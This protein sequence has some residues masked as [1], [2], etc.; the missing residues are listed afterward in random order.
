MTQRDEA[1]S[2]SNCASIFSRLYGKYVTVG[3]KLTLGLVLSANIC[4][5]LF[6]YHNWSAHKRI[7]EQVDDVMAIKDE[8]LINLRDKVFEMERNYLSIP[9]Q[10]A[11]DPFSKQLSWIQEAYQVVSTQTIK[12]RENYTTIFSRDERR[13][14][15]LGRL[16]V[17]EWESK[18]IAAHIALDDDQ[19]I[20]GTLIILILNSETPSATVEKITHEID[21]I[22]KIGFDPMELE[23]RIL[24]LGD[25]LVQAG[26]NAEEHRNQI[27]YKIE[28][29]QNRE[30]DLLA[31][32]IL[33]N[34]RFAILSVITVLLTALVL[35]ILTRIIVE[36]P[37]LQLTRVI[38]A[39]RQGGSPEIPYL[40]RT[41]QIGLLSGALSDFNE[42]VIEL[43]RSE[44]R[45]RKAKQAAEAANLAKS[46]FLANMSHEI[47]TP[48]NGVLGMLQLLNATP[49]DGSQLD[50]VETARTSAHSLLTIINDILDF[51][52]IEA[53]RLELETIHF[54]LRE[55]IDETRSVMF[56]HAE[57]KNLE[58]TAV[59][60]PDVPS[61]FKGD[62]G[63]IRQIIINLLSNAIKFT[64]KG[65][66]MLTANLI[67]E[68]A[69]TAPCK[70]ELKI[71]VTAFQRINSITC[72]LHFPSWMRPSQENMVAQDW[73]WPSQNN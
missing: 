36:R 37:L 19:L 48:M 8:L 41:D 2:A 26:I 39:I 40:N 62:P 6:T 7:A 20:D 11:Y 63:R 45:V 47:R 44:K 12:G 1:I 51:S 59:I 5:S 34:Q 66:V 22:K 52:K 73:D 58:L 16:V 60:Q 25:N 49:L 18:V 10:F 32:K 30:K 4:M 46:Q 21:R 55:L 27:L 15:N 54:N 53:G 13:D 17:K 31:L 61:L 65:N 3:F 56:F 28:D 35:F 70:S 42:T 14:L 67:Q 9:H 71:R 38:S 72:S 23:G 57:K 43:K 68:T 69:D 64:A 24:A 50:L 33:L 29:I